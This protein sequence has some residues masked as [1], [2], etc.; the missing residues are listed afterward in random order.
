MTLDNLNCKKCGLCRTRKCVVNGAGTTT[1]KIVLVGE[2]PGK[3]EDLRGVPFIGLAGKL[4]DKLL[5]YAGLNRSDIFITNVV[6][7]IPKAPPP[8]NVREPGPEEVLACSEY[9]EQ[10]MSA[11]KPTVIVPMGN[12][13]LRYIMQVQKGI[14]ITKVRGTELW[15]EKYKCKIMPI[16][17][18]AAI[19]RQPKHEYVTKEDLKR[20][21]TSSEFSELTTKKVGKYITIDNLTSL[22][23]LVDKLLNVEDFSFDLETTGLNWQTNKILCI[24]FSYESGLAYTVPLLRYN[25]RPEEYTHL[26][27]RKVRKKIDGVW[28][29]L[30]IKEIPQV[31]TRVVD[32]YYPF[33][34]TEQDLVLSLLQK[35]LAS[36]VKKIA[37]NGKF[38]CKFLAQYNLPVHNFT[39]DTML[40]HYLLNEN[41]EGMHGLK[42]CAWQ[43]TDMGGYDN[44]L[45]EWFKERKIADK[46]RNYAHLPPQMLYEYAAKDA[47]VTY[48][49]KTIFTPMLA[50]EGLTLFFERLIMLLSDTLMKAEIDGTQ[51]DVVY[52]QQLKKEL[53]EEQII[54]EK[55]IKDQVVVLRNQLRN[56]LT[57]RQIVITP[58]M[59][60][61]LGEININSPEQ[62]QVLLF[63]QLK[64]PVLKQTKGGKTGITQPSTD[65]EVLIELAKR[66]IIPKQILEY[67]KLEKLL[68]TYI[69]GIEEALDE[70]NRIHSTFL[71]HGTVTGRLAS[72]EHNLQNIPRDDKRI[73]KLFIAKPG[74]KLIEADYAQAEFRHW[75]NYSGDEKMLADLMSGSDIHR[76][77]AS[78][79]LGILID[80]VTK[81]Q[82]QQ[83]KGVVFGL[84]YG[85]GA[86]SLAEEYGLSEGEAKKIISIFFGRYPRAEVWL[87][88]AIKTV[89]QYKQ[90]RNIFGR[91]RRLP[92]IDSNDSWLRSEAERQALNSPIQS[93]ASDMNCNAANRIKLAFAEHLNGILCLL[94][95]DS[96]L[97]EVPENE[98]VE[99]LNI[100]KKELER[101]T[102]NVV[103]P[104]TSEFKVGT[105]WGVLNDCKIKNGDWYIIEKSNGKEVE[106]KL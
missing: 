91:L 92:G 97:Y 101:P 77:T 57:V 19:L 78:E 63:E 23:M 35:V 89:R 39:Y 16:F 60:I 46:N 81:D 72:R 64:L 15:S 7:C 98:L 106:V 36:D 14:S 96:L 69:S 32:E 95:H 65:E 20:I 10:E 34:E 22:Q 82:R 73:K 59:E 79:V 99:S 94:V 62:L 51:I 6:R 70:N 30:G 24:S 80:Q 104:M 76:L 25:G 2:A 90:I 38:D 9:F 17:H 75:A 58:E 1:A 33:W 84:M 61:K 42:G 43:Y 53:T 102:Q 47:D 48:R 29:D 13:A 5:L 4:L 21:K 66:H 103:V 11:L 12:S 37:H 93:A 3:D 67:R 49:L 45:E 85:R 40:A 68:G 50:S 100:I 56:D 55:K 74:W 31:K 54:I 83:A 52:M 18:P 28:V 8:Q 87:R 88:E 26:V 71:I 27:Q 41:A 44:V 105:R 86:K